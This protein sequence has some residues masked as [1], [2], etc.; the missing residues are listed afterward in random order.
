MEVKYFLNEKNIKTNFGVYVSASSGI[1][2][3]PDFKPPLTREWDEE[4]G[5]V[6]DLDTLRLKN[7]EITLECF[8]N[9]E[10]NFEFIT[11]L[12]SFYSE[13]LKAGFKRLRIEV[14]SEVPPLVYDV[15]I[16]E[17]ISITKKWSTGTQQGNFTIRLI[18]PNPRKMIFKFVATSSVKKIEITLR[19]PSGWSISN[20]LSTFGDGEIKNYNETNFEYN[21]DNDII[22]T[23]NYKAAGDYYIILSG[24]I[25]NF[26]PSFD[27][28]NTELLWQAL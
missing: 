10:S 18:D 27:L 6:V 24:V 22:I 9:A 11:K 7:R 13:F 16:A 21:E 1:L 17:K 26:E 25:D 5:S 4:H 19:P 28:T 8:I 2:D 23:H 12:N 3:L 14:G 20:I 15:Y